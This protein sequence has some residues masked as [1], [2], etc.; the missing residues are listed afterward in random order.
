[1]HKYIRAVLIA[2]VAVALLA[3]CT[4][5]SNPPAAAAHHSSGAPAPSTAGG[6]TPVSSAS[7]PPGGTASSASLRITTLHADQT[8]TLPATIGYQV[9]GPTI[10]A[11]AGYRVRVQVDTHTLD[12]PIAAPTGTVRLPLD[13]FLAGRRDLTFTLLG[14]TG[15]PVPESVVTIH[16]VLIIG[17]K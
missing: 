6:T 16:N 15:T 8:L 5:T 9:A 1:M 7:N 4:S 13:K 2:G 14:P 10:N 3:G 12:L 11:V 17:P